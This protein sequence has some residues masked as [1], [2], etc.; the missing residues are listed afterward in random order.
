ML[1][2]LLRCNAVVK[3]GA[4]YKRARKKASHESLKKAYYKR[5]KNRRRREANPDYYNS[6][7]YRLV[8]RT[9]NTDIVCQI[10]YT[11]LEGNVV[12]ASAYGHELT[13]YGV[14]GSLNNWAAAYATGLLV[15]RRVLTQL[16]PADKHEG[17][18]EPD[19]TLDMTEAVEDA[20][21]PFK[22]FL[23]AESKHIS[24]GSRAFAAMKGA[25]DGGLFIRHDGEQRFPGH[26]AEAKELDSEVLRS[27]IYG[28]DVADSMRHLKEK[29][30]DKYK[31]QF[32]KFIAAGVGPD[33]LEEMY[34][35]AHNAIRAD[36]AHVP[37]QNKKKP[38]ADEKT[39][40][41]SW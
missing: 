22:C 2:S 4:Y 20:P 28:G 27:Y 23:D 38:A 26:D 11:K 7:K 5:V 31:K 1:R 24:T 12:L 36:P 16:G 30:D 17:V 40:I 9:T 19:G 8:V 15:A 32:S 35:E 13:K 21:R 39:R 41:A 18:T 6:P 37:T 25:S 33:D 14:K 10:A 34:R 3:S 29:D